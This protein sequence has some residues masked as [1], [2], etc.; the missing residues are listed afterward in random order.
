MHYADD[1][2][3]PGHAGGVLVSQR[4]DDTSAAFFLRYTVLRYATDSGCTSL[5]FPSCLYNLPEAVFHC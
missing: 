5:S 2:H 4:H 3:L 1:P